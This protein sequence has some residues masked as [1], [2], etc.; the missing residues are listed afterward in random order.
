MSI[1]GT[2]WKVFCGGSCCGCC[3]AHKG[4]ESK[5]HFP[6]NQKELE[7]FGATWLNKVLKDNGTLTGSKIVESVTFDD[8]NSAGLLGEMCVVNVVY[9]DGTKQKLMAKFRPPDTDSRI[10]T[11]LFNLCQNEFDFYRTVQPEMVDMLRIP[12]LVFGDFH[13]PSATFIM[14][15]EYMNADFRRIQE[16]IPKEQSVVVMKKMA[17]LHSIFW[18]G[19]TPGNVN[20]DFIQRMDEGAQGLIPKVTAKALKTFY[21]GCCRAESTKAPDD[22]KE[23]FKRMFVPATMKLLQVRVVLHMSFAQSWFIHFISST[24]LT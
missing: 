14:L 1:P 15:F 13:R 8:N 4:E 12:K 5:A 9:S 21:T 11:T 20:I 18:K 24:R 10:T 2:L 22:L 17:L 3:C 6:R 16:D 19:A 23:A 7:K